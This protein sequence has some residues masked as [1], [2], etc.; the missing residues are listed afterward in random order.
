MMSLL[1]VFAY[2]VMERFFELHL[3]RRHCRVLASRGGREF[4]PETFPRMVAL[5]TLFL[6]ALLGESYPWRITSGPVTVALLTLFVFLQGAR[7]WCIASLGEYWNTR[8]VLVP[9]GRVTKTGPYRFFPHPNYLVVTLEFIVLP[10]LMHAPYTLALFF[11]LN[12]LV[13]R[14][15]ICLEER[16]LR[17][18]T[19]YN[20]QFPLR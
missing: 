9:G 18:F 4:Y 17:E 1:W 6:L 7:Y 10:L 12:L 5:H 16:A 8:I 11:P 3:S 14:Q 19:D 2:L 20:E 15:R 13:V